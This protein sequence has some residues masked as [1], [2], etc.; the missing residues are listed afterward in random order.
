MAHNEQFHQDLL[1]L[2]FFFGL[3]ESLFASVDKSKF[4]NGRV[5]FR[6]LGMKGL[7]GK[8]TFPREVIAN[9]FLPLFRKG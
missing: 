3:T 5:H 4:K 8:D 9:L 2:P 7:R 1:C 6:N